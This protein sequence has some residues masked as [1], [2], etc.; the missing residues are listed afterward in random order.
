MW[1]FDDKK[2]HS[3]IQLSASYDSDNIYLKWRNKNH[4][5]KLPEEARLAA[6]QVAEETAEVM[7]AAA[8]RGNN[9]SPK[10]RRPSPNRKPGRLKSNIKA[11]KTETGGMVDWNNKHTANH[12][13]AIE[14]GATPHPITGPNGISFRGHIPPGPR[15]GNINVPMVNHP[16]NA[17]QPYIRPSVDWGK[18]EL[19]RRVTGLGSGISY[20]SRGSDVSFIP[21]GGSIRTKALSS[22]SRGGKK[23]L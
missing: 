21:G 20:Q 11:F 8:P 15:K 9:K 16:G 17:A 2:F 10:M 3:T 18:D 7:T 1:E 19:W 23:P 13:A 14:F 6:F 22:E 4:W 5:I 12:W